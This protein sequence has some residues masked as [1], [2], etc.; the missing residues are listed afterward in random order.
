MGF[1]LNQYVAEIQ[2]YTSIERPY[3]QLAIFLQKAH[4]CII[5][6]IV[7]DKHKGGIKLEIWLTIA[8]NAFLLNYYVCPPKPSFGGA[9]KL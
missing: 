3:V 7:L 8:E 1:S 4:M 6:F 9:E 2:H 5:A